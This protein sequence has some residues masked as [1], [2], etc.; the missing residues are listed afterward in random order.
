MAMAEEE[1]IDKM[2]RAMCV[3]DGRTPEAVMDWAINDWDGYVKAARRQRRAHLAMQEAQESPR[4]EEVVEIPGTNVRAGLTEEMPSDILDMIEGSGV[5]RELVEAG[6]QTGP[7]PQKTLADQGEEVVR[8]QLTRSFDEGL[9]DR[10]QRD[11][12]F[13]LAIVKEHREMNFNLWTTL[14]RVIGERDKFRR[15]AGVDRL[16]RITE[17]T[18]D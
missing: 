18:D 12:E 9:I 15:L 1:I 17:S 3:A 2:A 10:M 4:T 8:N 11:R 14:Q 13:C 7:I 6:A 5:G 16:N